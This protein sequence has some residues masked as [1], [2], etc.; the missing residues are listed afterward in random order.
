MSESFHM[1]ETRIFD[2]EG[3]LIKM[4]SSYVPGDYKYTD[5]DEKYLAWLDNRRN[6][7]TIVERNDSD[8]TIEQEQEIE[9]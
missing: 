8:A 1:I 2:S 7:R 9:A 4:V 3:D 6:K 5:S